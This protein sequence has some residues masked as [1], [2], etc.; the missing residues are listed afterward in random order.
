[1]TSPFGPTCP[2][3]A[4]PIAPKMPGADHGA[5]REHDQVAGAEHALERRPAARRRRAVLDGFA[6]EELRHG[7]RSSASCR[8]EAHTMTRKPALYR[9]AEVLSR[10]LRGQKPPRSHHRSK[11]YAVSLD[12]TATPRSG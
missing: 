6:L 12:T 3:A 9:V 8:P 10:V 11:R 5:D 4:V 2:A 1:M 7:L